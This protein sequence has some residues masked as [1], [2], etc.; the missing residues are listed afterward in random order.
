MWKYLQWKSFL[1]ENK[2]VLKQRSIKKVHRTLEG[3]Q[4][5]TE[6]INGGK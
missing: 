2:E 6:T 4:N 1:S 5:E 3:I